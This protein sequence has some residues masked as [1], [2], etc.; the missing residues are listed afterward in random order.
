MFIQSSASSLS[1]CNAKPHRASSHPRRPH[2]LATHQINLA[3]PSSRVIQFQSAPAI[4]LIYFT[5]FAFLHFVPPKAE[6]SVCRL[7]V[8]LL[9]PLRQ[10]HVFEFLHLNPSLLP[11][12]VENPT[13]IGRESHIYCAAHFEMPPTSVW[14]P[15]LLLS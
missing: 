6:N 11:Q 9:L 13:R 2:I 15:N 1:N 7:K 14:I 3:F 10:S 12:S 8:Q 5:S 4:S